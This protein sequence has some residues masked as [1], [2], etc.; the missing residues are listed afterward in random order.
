MGQSDAFESPRLLLGS[1]R[2]DTTDF[3]SRA[4]AF[5]A[6]CFGVRFTQVD[7]KSGEQVVKYQIGQKIP[8][9]LRVLASHVVNDLRHSL[10][11]AVNCAAVELGGKRSNYFPFAK[12]ALDIDRVIKDNCKTVPAALKAILKGFQPYG[13][14]DDVLYSLNRIAGPNK[15]QLVVRMDFDLTHIMANDFAREVRGPAEVGFFE[16]DSAKQ[17]IEVARI[18]PGGHIMCADRARFPLSITLGHRQATDGQPATA[19]LSGLTSKVEGILRMIEAETAKL[20]LA[21]YRAGP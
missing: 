14:G 17:E 20:K 5:L 21:H 13:G 3:D 2:H 11:Q 19:F 7:S 10:D 18:G 1:A 8:G 6:G 16:W 15:H 12:D 4:R 9:R